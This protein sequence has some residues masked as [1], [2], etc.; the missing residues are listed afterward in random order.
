[1]CIR[2]R[3]DTEFILFLRK[4]GG[5]R[6]VS[7]LQKALSMLTRD[8][9]QGWLRSFWSDIRGASTREGHPAPYPVELAERL[10]RLFS[11]AGDTILDPF[12]GTGAT[13]LAAMAT[14]RNSIGIDIEPKY[15][16]IAQGHLLTA[17]NRRRKVDSVKPMVVLD[18]LPPT[19]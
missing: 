6:S 4:P 19:D 5:Y 1:M 12:I 7:P 18:G 9:M 2:D 14:G 3:N 13:S 16:T 8:E 11:F 10:I 15:L 17:R